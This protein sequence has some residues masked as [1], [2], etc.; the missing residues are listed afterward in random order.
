MITSGM[1][2]PY[3]PLFKAK[4]VEIVGV[5]YFHDDTLDFAPVLRQFQNKGL[6]GL[7][8]GYNDNDGSSDPAET[9]PM[10]SGICDEKWR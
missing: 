9:F 8:I 3:E 4:G 5:A 1:T 6:D 10:R 2:V 7:F